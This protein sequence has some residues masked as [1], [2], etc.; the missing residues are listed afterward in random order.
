MRQQF[1]RG[2]LL[3]LLIE[4]MPG[5]AAGASPVPVLV[6]DTTRIT[7]E[8]GSVFDAHLDRLASPFRQTG[9]GVGWSTSYRRGGFTVEVGRSSGKATS[10][11]D[12]DR[13]PGEETWAGHLDLAYVRRIGG[14]D[15][16]DYRVGASLAGLFFVRRHAYGTSGRE[17]F[18]DLMTPLSLVAEAHRRLGD[19]TVVGDRL[20]V[21]VASILFRSPYYATKE[22]P[23]GSFATPFG[24]RL[25][26]NRLSI[27]RP[28]TRRTRLILTHHLTFYDASRHADVRVV[29]QELRLGLAVLFGGGGA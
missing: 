9:L 23:G 17:Y 15:R 20:S 12:D 3:A 26:R 16:T 14:G 2:G 22:F 10:T 29:Q 21:G 7:A 19:E 5:P 24:L 18:A 28:L 8:V 6:A 4:A 25:V 11:V 13:A 1:I 27:E